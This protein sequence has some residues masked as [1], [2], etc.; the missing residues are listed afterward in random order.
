[1]RITSLFSMFPLALVASGGCGLTIDVEALEK[2]TSAG[3]ETNSATH[4][5]LNMNV[6]DDIVITGGAEKFEANVRTIEWRS[7]KDTNEPSRVSVHFEQDGT[8]VDLITRGGEESVTLAGIA[9]GA[10][11]RLGVIADVDASLLVVSNFDGAVSLE[12]DCP[13]VATAIRG[14]LE[15]HGRDVAT[16][17]ATGPIDIVAE[18]HI[19]ALV[20]GPGTIIGQDSLIIEL[21]EDIVG[22]LTLSSGPQRPI[23][24]KVS[25]NSAFTLELTSG[26]GRT[27]VEAG[28]TD[29]DIFDELEVQTVAFNG[30]GPSV[31]VRADGEIRV[32]EREPSAK[33]W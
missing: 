5:R 2:T 27:R 9:V 17:E 16:V 3:F 30:G 13:I 12:S 7:P 14:P 22:P 20:R 6:L 8:A 4:F 33:S 15:L 31:T 1:M 10:P 23:T 25:A 24:V 18:E 26:S 21:Y 11:S 29:L 19:E 28:G 32:V